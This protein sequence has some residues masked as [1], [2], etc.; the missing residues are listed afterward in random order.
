[1]GLSW[2]VGRV[3]T[4]CT[5]AVIDTLLIELVREHDFEGYYHWTIAL[6][7]LEIFTCHRIVMP[8]I[9]EEDEGDV[10]MFGGGITMGATSAE[11][12][13]ADPEFLDKVLVWVK[14]QHSERSS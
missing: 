13:L 5:T 7:R 10:V 3:V 11:F 1:M 4:T 8:P 2:R 9:R 12:N 14:L 6:G